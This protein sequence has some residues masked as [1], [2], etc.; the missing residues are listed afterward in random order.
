M[1]RASL[2]SKA[3][4][5]VPKAPEIKGTAV[6]ESYPMYAI[7]VKDFLQLKKW[8]PHQVCWRRERG[9]GTGGAGA[10]PA[11]RTLRRPFPESSS[12]AQSLTQTRTSSPTAGSSR[13]TT[14]ARR[15]R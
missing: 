4:L 8:R 9:L 7:P 6:K 14:H 15:T 13:W 5:S 12:Q 3:K 10:A 1:V 2:G 11:A